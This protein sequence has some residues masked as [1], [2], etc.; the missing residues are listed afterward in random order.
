MGIEII[1]NNVQDR[2]TRSDLLLPLQDLSGDFFVLENLLTTQ[3]R[4]F[5]R[6]LVRLNEAGGTTTNLEKWTAII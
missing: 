3:N 5:E 1:V 4:T 2:Q 6:L